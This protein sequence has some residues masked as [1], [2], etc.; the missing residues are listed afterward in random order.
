M[1]WLTSAIAVGMKN[2]DD[3]LQLYKQTITGHKYPPYNRVDG[4]NRTSMGKQK[5]VSA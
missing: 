4:H 2:G 1:F 5:T 3:R